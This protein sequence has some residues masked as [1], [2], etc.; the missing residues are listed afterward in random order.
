MLLTIKSLP[1][2]LLSSYEDARKRYAEFSDANQDVILQSIQS[3]TEDLEND[4]Q[5]EV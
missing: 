4:M 3:K 2:K 1:R 5:F